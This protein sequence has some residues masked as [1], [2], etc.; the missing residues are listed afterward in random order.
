MKKDGKSVVI[1]G[2]GWLGQHLRVDFISK[3]Y[4]VEA[5]VRDPIKAAE[6]GLNYFYVMP[7]G[8]CDHNISLQNA[9]WICCIPPSFRTAERHYFT[10]LESALDLAVSLNMK[11]FLLCSS[12]GVYSSTSTVMTEYLPIDI[13]SQKQQ[14]LLEA[15][16]RVLENE[17]NKVVRLAGLI[18]P[19]R[20]P[21]RFVAGKVLSSSANERVNMIHQLD[22]SAAIVHLVEK[23]ELSQSIYNLVTPDHPTKQAFYAD[24]CAQLASAPPRFESTDIIER[25]IDGQAIEALGFTYRYLTLKDALTDC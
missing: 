10:V 14:W 20:H 4:Q 2:T 19:K 6:Q 21:G 23:W 1:L 16:A 13:E 7:D 25:I 17:Q 18:G 9:V 5:T 8:L 11:G 15:E 24:A 22:A 12:T 3:K